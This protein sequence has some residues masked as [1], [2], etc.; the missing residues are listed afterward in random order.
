MGGFPKGQLEKA[1]AALTDD[2]RREKDSLLL[3]A[4]IRRIVGWS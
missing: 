4:R 3:V 1:K 2:P